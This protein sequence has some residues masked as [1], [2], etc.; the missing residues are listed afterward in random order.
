M[1]LFYFLSDF[2]LGCKNCLLE[3]NDTFNIFCNNCV[4]NK[5]LLT[6][7]VVCSLPAIAWKLPSFPWSSCSSPS[8]LLLPFLL[9]KTQKLV[10]VHVM[11]VADNEDQIL[12]CEVLFPKLKKQKPTTKNDSI[13]CLFMLRKIDQILF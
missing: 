5:G 8:S 13:N 12:S 6:F 3:L 9:H 10:S 2:L 1:L 11:W 7:H 4:G